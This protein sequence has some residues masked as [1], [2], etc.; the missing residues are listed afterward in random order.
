MSE[1]WSVCL[2]RRWRKTLQMCR[3]SIDNHPICWILLRNRSA[4]YRDHRS[5]QARWIPA[6]AHR[7]T[8]PFNGDGLVMLFTYCD[9]TDLVCDLF[10]VYERCFINVRIRIIISVTITIK[11]RY[12]DHNVII[13]LFFVLSVNPC[14]SC[15][16]NTDYCQPQANKIS[17]RNCFDDKWKNID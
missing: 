7:H 5:V 10:W 8:M 3:R 2:R 11:L 12:A 16:R 4:T 1:L 14:W 9:S 17:G 6:N 15:P 13:Y